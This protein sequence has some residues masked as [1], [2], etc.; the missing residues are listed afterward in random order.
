MEPV[1][2][3]HTER[4]WCCDYNCWG[5]PLEILH[6]RSDV[7]FSQKGPVLVFVSWKIFLLA[8]WFMRWEKGISWLLMLKEKGNACYP[9]T[10]N[11][12]SAS[13]FLN[14]SPQASSLFTFP[15]V[16]PLP[17][18]LSLSPSLLPVRSSQLVHMILKKGVRTEE[19]NRQE[20]DD[21]GRASSG[22]C[23]SLTLLYKVLVCPNP[24]G[25]PKDFPS[26]MKT[27]NKH[28]CLLTSQ[29]TQQPC[30]SRASCCLVFE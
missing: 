18:P 12:L 13:L 22:Y 28:N 10:Y 29:N 8:A 6:R 19:G 26:M 14:L 21:S 7:K 27:T 17:P 16:L 15:C 2:Q 4:C 1:T 24:N 9:A 11:A 3:K 30:L 5:P 20:T 23:N 25:R